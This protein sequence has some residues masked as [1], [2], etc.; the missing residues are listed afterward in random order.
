MS[1]RPSESAAE[2][3]APAR[4][5]TPRKSRKNTLRGGR[6]LHCPEELAQALKSELTVDGKPATKTFPRRDQFAAELVYFSDCILNNR[7]PEPS[8]QEG[9][10]EVRIMQAL[11]DSAQ[12]GKPVSVIP[13]DIRQRPGM[14][15]E[16]EKPPVS[17][18]DLVNASS[19][20]EGG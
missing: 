18:P 12:T 11:I 6:A 14:K 3:A 5:V 19:P 13:A 4:P 15:Q 8:G 2:T 10:A 16:I 17:P 20:G 9:L 1:Q 7:Q